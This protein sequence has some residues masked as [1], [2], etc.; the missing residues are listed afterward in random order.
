[1]PG[2]AVAQ[3]RGYQAPKKYVS[4]GPSFIDSQWAQ[5][6]SPWDFSGLL[7]LF[8]PGFGFEALGAY[9]VADNVLTNIDDSLSIEAGLGFFAASSN[10]IG[11]SYSYSEVEIPIMARWDFRIPNSKFIAGPELGFTYFTAG[12][13][14]VNNVQ[15]AQS[16]G[17]LYLQLGGFGMWQFNDKFAIRGELKIINYTVIAF[18]VTYFL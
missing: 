7:G 15:Y 11:G 9:R 10:V 2:S 4:S 1:M 8:N 13:V 18:G 5:S 16:G 3:N 12:T 17:G 14:T 6:H